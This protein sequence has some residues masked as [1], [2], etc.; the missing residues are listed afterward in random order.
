MCPIGGTSEQPQGTSE[1]LFLIITNA[2]ISTTRANYKEICVTYTLGK[3]YQ[4]LKMGRNRKMYPI[5]KFEKS[6][7]KDNNSF[8]LSVPHDDIGLGNV[9]TMSFTGTGHL[10][11]QCHCYSPSSNT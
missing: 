11:S 2:I 10:S 9:E 7:A 3:A 5:F 4:N 8:V 6:T 1:Q